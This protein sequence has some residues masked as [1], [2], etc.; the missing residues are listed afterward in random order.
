MLVSCDSKGNR[1]CALESCTKRRHMSAFGKVSNFTE[2]NSHFVTK[3]RPPLLL[4]R[5]YTAH[6]LCAS[7]GPGSVKKRKAGSP[8]SC[9]TWL[10]LSVL[11]CYGVS[12]RSAT[13]L[14]GTCRPFEAER[15][16][17]VGGV[18]IKRKYRWDMTP[19]N[20]ARVPA[21][22]ALSLWSN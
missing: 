21:S 4:Q 16:A 6:T 5:C 11:S 20:C 1:S 12:D 2:V 13:A 19:D 7:M 3:A 22:H 17:P 10:F 18:V 15:G 8:S 14:P 9:A